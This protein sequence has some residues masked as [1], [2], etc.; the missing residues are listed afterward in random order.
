[1]PSSTNNI[2][3]ENASRNTTSSEHPH[4]KRRKRPGTLAIRDIRRWQ[5]EIEPILARGPLER[6]IRSIAGEFDPNARWQEVSL[7]ALHRD[8]EVFLYRTFR[9]TNLCAIQAGRSTIQGKDVR[10]QQEICG[11]RP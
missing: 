3:G 5:K 4:K 9:N 1:M 7:A 10:L 2:K 8:L 6:L 11:N